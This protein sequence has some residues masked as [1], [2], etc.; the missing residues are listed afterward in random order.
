MRKITTVTRK[1]QVTI[2]QVVRERLQISYGD[3]VEFAFNEQGQVILKPIKT[4]LDL[5][6]GVL[7]KERPALE[8][9]N[10]RKAARDWVGGRKGR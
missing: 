9:E 1:G 7:E 5:L 6:Y 10:Q 8:L 2:P 4:D 3:K